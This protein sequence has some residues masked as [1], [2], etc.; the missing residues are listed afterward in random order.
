MG[1]SKKSYEQYRWELTCLAH[2]RLKAM[3]SHDNSDVLSKFISER[4][5]EYES[6]YPQLKK[7]S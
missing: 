6:Q 4:I 2:A 7:V 5:A 3:Q 1:D